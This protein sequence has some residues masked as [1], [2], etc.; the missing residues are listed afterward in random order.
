[1]KRFLIHFWSLVKKAWKKTWHFLWEDDSIWSWLANVVIIFVFV[2]FLFYPALGLAVGTSYPIVAVVSGSM[3]HDG[4]FDSWWDLQNKYY[5]P[6]AIS[7][8]DFKTFSFSNGFNKG[9]IMFLKGKNPETITVGDVL[10]FNSWTKDPLIHRVIEVKK[11]G[12]NYYFHTKGDHNT[13]SLTDEI[14]ISEDRLVGVAYFRVPYLG[15]TK[16]VFVESINWFRGSSS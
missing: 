2:K 12:D 11:V 3:E 14:S 5:D 4:N 7:K 6:Y 10:V 15:W 1:M 8:D 16:L 9:D 13:A